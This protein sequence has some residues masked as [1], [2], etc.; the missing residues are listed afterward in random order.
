VGADPCGQRAK[1]LK[2]K[3]FPGRLTPHVATF[4]RTTVAVFSGLA[5][6]VDLSTTLGAAPQE[7]G[8]A[9]PASLERIKEALEKPPVRLDLKWP[10]PVTTFKTRVDQRTYVLSLEEQLRKEFTLTLLQRQSHVW[11]SRCCGFN[12]L[13]LNQLATSLHKAL[14]RRK[15]RQI[16]QQI[17]RELAELDAARRQ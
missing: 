12:L 16:R 5:F 8:N 7:S 10:L 1:D 13:S 2:P 4:L 15:V 9:P 3:P 11:A 6:V 14:Q 17:A